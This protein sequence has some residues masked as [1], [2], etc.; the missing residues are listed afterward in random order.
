MIN[1]NELNNKNLNFKKFIKILKKK[2]KI[3]S[4]I[5]IATHFKDLKK[6]IKFAK[7]LKKADLKFFKFN[8]NKYS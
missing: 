1:A 4:I 6:S 5:R 2:N 8:A 7:I 3:I